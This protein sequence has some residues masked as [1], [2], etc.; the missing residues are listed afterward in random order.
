MI[1]GIDRARWVANVTLAYLT[2]HTVAHNLMQTLISEI[3]KGLTPIP[4]PPPPLAVKNLRRPMPTAAEI[5]R[6]ILYDGL[7]SFEDGKSH[8]MLRLH[9]RKR[10]LTPQAYPDKWGLPINYP[11]TAPSVSDIKS[12]KARRSGFSASA[13]R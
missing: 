10:G 12:R 2:N 8:K 4:P 11:M 3:D 5:N 13:G 9:L 7:I 1:K 6:S